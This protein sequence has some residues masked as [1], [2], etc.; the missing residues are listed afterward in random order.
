MGV[1]W[2]VTFP[3]PECGTDM[4]FQ[5]RGTPDEYANIVDYLSTFIGDSA[6]CVHCQLHYIAVGV[7]KVTTK[8]TYKHD[9]R[10]VESTTKTHKLHFVPRVC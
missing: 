4:A 7:A 6:L 5:A 9:D 3:C 10:L 8:V 2:D 1:I